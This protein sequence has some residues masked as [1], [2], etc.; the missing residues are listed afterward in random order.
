MK[1]DYISNYN[2]YGDHVVRLYDFDTVHAN[3]FRNSIQHTV[4]TNKQSL[5]LATID[6]I[7]RRNCQLVLRI[8]ETDEGIVTADNI[9]FFCDLTP[10]GYEQMVS[11][12]EPFCKKAT[13][14]YQW[15]YDIDNPTDFL[16]SPAGTW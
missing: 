10:A 3:K 1:L 14:G 15:L 2:K 8:A 6:F 9:N 7:E 13:K 4:I 11:L 12:L 5:D 16:F